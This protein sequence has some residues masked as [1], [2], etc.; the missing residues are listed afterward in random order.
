[1][2]TTAPTDKPSSTFRFR[3][4]CAEDV[5]NLLGLIPS[6]SVI[7]FASMRQDPFPDQYCEIEV[8]GFN[9]AAVREFCRSVEDGHVILQTLQSRDIY[10][11]QRDHSLQ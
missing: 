7:R 6:K 1:M 9:L 3:A 11:G 10:T 4:E 5:Q 2:N 8:K